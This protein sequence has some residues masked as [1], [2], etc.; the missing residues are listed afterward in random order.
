MLELKDLFFNKNKLIHYLIPHSKGF[1]EF[2]LLIQFLSGFLTT[3]P[4]TLI[5]L[6]RV[7]NQSI[8]S[9]H[10]QSPS[11]QETH[12]HDSLL[13]SYCFDIDISLSLCNV[14]D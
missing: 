12:T 2:S 3:L 6:N 8:L 14:H 13:H 9:P 7:T 11:L 5:I 1:I 10:A 4:L